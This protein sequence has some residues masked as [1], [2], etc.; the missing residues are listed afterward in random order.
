MHT[1]LIA[2]AAVALAL[3]GCA[4]TPPPA[5]VVDLQN[6]GMAKT[7]TPSTVDLASPAPATVALTVFSC[8][9]PAVTFVAPA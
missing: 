4:K 6:E 5:P 3:S 8:T 9:A 2:T 7:S 1:K